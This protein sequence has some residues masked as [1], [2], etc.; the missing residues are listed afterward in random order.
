M[1]NCF[2]KNNYERRKRYF[3]NAESEITLKNLQTLKLLSI[4]EV[5]MLPLTMITANL[6]ISGWQ[7]TVFH[8]AFLPA[9]ALL[10]LTILLYCHGGGGSRNAV[11]TLCLAFW[12]VIFIFVILIDVF[13]GAAAQS[14][15][16]P[17]LC[18]ALPVNFIMPMGLTFG[19]VGA[20]EAV[21]IIGLVLFKEPAVGQL[22]VFCAV[23][24]FVIAA[25]VYYCVIMLR[26]R[27]YENCAKYEHL[28]T[29][30]TLVP[31]LYNKQN[32]QELIIQYLEMN[33]PSVSCALIMLDVDDFKKINDTYGHYTGDRTLCH[34]GEVL[35][36][37]FRSTD[38]VARFG[39]DEFIAFTKGHSEDVDI[40][41]KCESISAALKE[42]PAEDAGMPVFCSIGAVTVNRR[43]AV[44]FDELFRQTDKALYEAKNFGKNRC[45]LRHYH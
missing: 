12:S 16:M 41:A 1:L 17:L 7:M 19:V 3:R 20:F 10:C 39:G 38:I 11:M 21:Y 33:S 35:Q 4:I 34:V 2:F 25:V 36:R 15:F 31:G 14:C 8:L 22:D 9:S 27:D 18:V 42:A 29:R 28:S 45:V 5:V 26:S 44:D 24:A 43:R 6:I 23:Y 40:T 37:V 30:D 32:G 13:S